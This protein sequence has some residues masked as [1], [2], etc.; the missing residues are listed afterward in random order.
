[1]ACRCSYILSMYPYQMTV[2]QCSCFLLAAGYRWNDNLN[3]AGSNGNYWSGSLNPDNDNNAY[4][5]NF[6][7]GNWDWSWNNRYN[8]QSVRAVC[9]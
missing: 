1:M 4:I 5:L 2:E 7:S 6:N 3:N 8:G 9:P